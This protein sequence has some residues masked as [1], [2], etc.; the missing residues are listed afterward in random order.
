MRSNMF[1][2]MLL[3]ALFRHLILKT[4]KRRIVSDSILPYFPC[5]IHT[6]IEAFEY[7]KATFRAPA[8]ST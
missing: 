1:P 8:K 3:K 2:N 5:P 4:C 7:K 6:Q